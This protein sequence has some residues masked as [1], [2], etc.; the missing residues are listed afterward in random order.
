MTT[1]LLKRGSVNGRYNLPVLL[2][3]VL[4][5]VVR[6]VL[7]LLTVL[8]TVQTRMLLKTG[9]LGR[10]HPADSERRFKVAVSAVASRVPHLRPTFSSPTANLT[11]SPREAK[12][13]WRAFKVHAFDP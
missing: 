7:L 1:P 3:G 13:L 9:G 12:V 10:R 8:P 11:L 5:L 4:E 6:R 2:G